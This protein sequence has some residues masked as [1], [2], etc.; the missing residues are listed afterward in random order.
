[1]GNERNLNSTLDYYDENNMYIENKIKKYE[2][3][4]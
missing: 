3:M 2:K 4:V 1:M